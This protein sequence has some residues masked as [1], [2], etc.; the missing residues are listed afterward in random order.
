[1]SWLK[2]Q[3]LL[4]YEKYISIGL[5]CFFTFVGGV[6]STGIPSGLYDFQKK[7]YFDNYGI[8]RMGI[9][10]IGCCELFGAFTI[11]AF[12]NSQLSALGTLALLC[13]SCGAIAFH[14]YF[15]TAGDAIPAFTT[16]TLSAFLLYI[17]YRRGFVPI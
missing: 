9:L 13:T 6:K 2:L 5:G 8:P 10:G 1:M 4:V 15:D 3:K 16:C 11:M 14:L 17:K 7:K 12:R